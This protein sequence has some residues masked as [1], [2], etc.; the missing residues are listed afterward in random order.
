MMEIKI[1][2]TVGDYKIIDFYNNKSDIIRDKIIAM[3]KRHHILP[4]DADAH[5]R[6]NEV[7]V[8][9]LNEMG[10]VVG[11]VTACKKELTIPLVLAGRYV[12]VY[13]QF[14][15]PQDRQ[16]SLTSRLSREAVKLLDGKEGMDGLVV[17]MEN[18]KLMRGGF[19]KYFSRRGFELIDAPRIKQDVWFRDYRKINKA[20]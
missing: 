14:T 4:K 7:V 10:E 16:P 13:R 2:R 3:W 20:L 9:A 15:Q 5:K 12:F 8:A 17:V 6:A 18:K 11:V 1:L 19:R